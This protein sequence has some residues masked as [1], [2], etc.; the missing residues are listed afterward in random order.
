MKDFVSA[1][2]TGRDPLV[3]GENA[4]RVLRI[5]D[6]AYESARTGRT[7]KLEGP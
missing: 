3:T 5:L 1:I 6:A 2:R 4:V 7:V